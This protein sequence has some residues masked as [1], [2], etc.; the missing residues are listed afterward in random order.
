M[1]SSTDQR[2]EHS[3]LKIAEPLYRLVN[4]EIAPGTGV[5]PDH[6]W[7]ELAS[8]LAELAPQN[9]RLLAVRDEMQAAIDGWHRENPAFNADNY[10]TF[11]EKLGYLL[12][13][14]TDVDVS[15]TN[16]DSEIAT[17]VGPQLVVP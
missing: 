12:P 16:I 5:E 14:P 9:R 11:L 15:T 6:F 13:E 4:D 1:P 3:G 2:I 10:R 8:L 17:L 7:S